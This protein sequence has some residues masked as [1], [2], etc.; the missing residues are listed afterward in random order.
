MTSLRESIPLLAH[1]RRLRWYLTLT[2]SLATLAALFLLAWWGLV[3]GTIYLQRADPASTW[4][5]ILMGQ[6]LPALR[7]I[8]PSLLILVIP[9]LL[10]NAFFGYL[11]ARWLDLRL[12]NLR[13][14]TRAWQRGDFTASVQDEVQDEIGY[15]GR[16]LNA[17]AQELEHLL[18]MRQ[19]LAALEER[20]QLARDLHDSVKQQITAAS[21]Q[22]EAAKALLQMDLAA[23]L[24]SL[25]EAG[26]L[27]HAAQQE[28]NAVIF[29]LRPAKLQPG[30]LVQSLQDYCASWSRINRIEARFQSEVSWTPDAAVEQELFRFVQEALANVARHSQASLV[31]ILMS[32]QAGEACLSIQDNGLGFSPGALSEEGFGLH[33]MRWRI[34]NLGGRISIE[35]QPSQGTRIRAW[36]PWEQ[37]E[38]RQEIHGLAEGASDPPKEISAQEGDAPLHPGIG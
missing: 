27:A 3:A 33:S 23:A 4:G 38:S 11:N 13:Q 18:H 28:L 37:V 1:F 32:K 12:A 6:V 31:D 2:Y 20:N 35:S 17:M 22:V 29:E 26:N 25:T 34:E 8:L 19:E 36:I 5:E 9:A 14:A 30:S 7:V 15:F 16:E 24:A 21:Y 10:V